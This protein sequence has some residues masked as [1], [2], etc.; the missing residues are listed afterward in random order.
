MKDR[1]YL[2]TAFDARGRVIT[3]HYATTNAA[4]AQFGSIALTSG[5]ARYEVQYVGG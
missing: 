3:M 4:A 5:A 1:P 2:M